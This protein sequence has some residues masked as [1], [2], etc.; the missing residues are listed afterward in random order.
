MGPGEEGIEAVDALAGSNV[1]EDL[2]DERGEVLVLE[3]PPT[4]GLRRVGSRGDERGN[5]R[6]FPLA[7][8]TCRPDS[9]CTF[10]FSP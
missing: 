4:P 5:S 1:V 6:Q 9:C 3:S 2:L 8:V 10:R 7:D